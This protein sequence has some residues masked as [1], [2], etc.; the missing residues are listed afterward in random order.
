MGLEQTNCIRLDLAELVGDLSGARTAMK[1]IGLRQE[2][3]AF[4]EIAQ[5]ERLPGNTLAGIAFVI[6]FWDRRAAASAK[7]AYGSKCSY[8]PQN[9]IC[10]VTMSRDDLD[11]L[12][13]FETTQVVD[14]GDDLVSVDFFDVR[15]AAAA[16]AMSVTSSTLPPMGRINSRQSLEPISEATS[17]AEDISTECDDVHQ[18]MYFSP[19]SVD[20]QGG[21][22]QI[23]ASSSSESLMPKFLRSEQGLSLAQLSWGAMEKSR[24][25]RTELRLR[26]L[27]SSICERRALEQVLSQLGLLETVA[28]IQVSASTKSRGSGWATIKAKSVNDVQRIAKAFHGRMFRGSR[29]PIAVSFADGSSSVVGDRQKVTKLSARLGL[30]EPQRVGA[31]PSHVS[32]PPGLEPPPGLLLAVC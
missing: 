1:I 30:P 32:A 10:S 4:G 26:G 3:E 24:E 11:N 20:A 2:L 25:W 23:G 9:G 27:P 13:G 12:G 19:L 17:D 21:L 5:V 7:E 14:M 18:P 22:E 6:T 8:E 29:M 16:A 31:S 28:S 15:V